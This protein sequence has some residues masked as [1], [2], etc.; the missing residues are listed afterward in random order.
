MKISYLY[1]S[2]LAFVLLGCVLPSRAD[3]PSTNAVTD[4]WIPWGDSTCVSNEDVLFS[5]WPDWMV[6]AFKIGGAW[7]TNIPA[8]VVEAGDTNEAALNIEVDR[9]HLTNNVLMQLDYVDHSNATLML[10]LYGFPGTNDPNE[11]VFTSNLF[12]NLL[13]GGGGVTSRTFTIPFGLYTNATGIRLRRDAGAM[14][15]FDT[16]LSSDRDGDGYSD[17]EELAWGSDLDSAL[18]VP[19]AA[20][21]GQVFYVGVQMGVIHVLAT[22]NAADWASAHYLTLGIPG[23][24]TLSGLPLRQT[25]YPR[26]F[27]DVNGNGIPDDWEPRG[28]YQAPNGATSLVLTGNTSGVNITL[29]DPDLD[30]DGMSDAAERAMGLDPYA[31]ND[32]TRLPFLD[33]FETNT[34][35]V[36]DVNGQNGWIASPSNTVLVQTNVVWEGEQAIRFHSGIVTSEVHRLF[37]QLPGQ[38]SW[39][40]FHAVAKVDDIPQD[41][42]NQ[43]AAFLFDPQGRLVVQDGRKPAGQKWVTL[44][45][46]PPVKQES[47]VRLSISMDFAAQR[48]LICLN[49]MKVAEDLGFG[50]PASELHEFAMEGGSGGLD[51]FSVSTNVPAGLSLDGDTL[52]DDW[53]MQYMGNTN[54]TESGDSDHD[55]V[56]NGEEYR[57]GTSP[58]NPD[59]DNDSMPDGW[60]IAH[61]LNPASA[62]DGALDS[63]LDG[64]SNTSE[65]LHGTDLAKSDSDN[66]GL[67]DGTEVN[68]WHSNPLASDSDLDGFKDADEVQRGTD[69]ADAESHPASHWRNRLKL[70][71]RDGVL[72]NSLADVPVLIRLTPER[73]DYSQCAAAGRDILFTDATGAPLAFELERWNPGGESLFWVR[74]PDA[75]GTNS[76]GYFWLHY[77]NPEATNSSNASATWSTNFLGVWHLSETNTVLSDSAPAAHPATN[78]G[79]V[80]VTGILGN[81]RNFRGSDSVIVPPSALATISNA[82]SISFWQ[83][84]ATNQ[85]LGVTCFEGTSV[86]GRELNAHVPWSDSNVYW[87]AFGNYDRINKLATTNL[88]KGGWNHWTFT[89][90]RASGIMRIYVNG[91]LWHSGTGKTRAYSPVTA[92]WFG[93]AASGSSGYVGMLDELRVE[94]LAQSPEWIRFQ[95]K[96]MTD[97]ILVYGEQQVSIAGTA[98]GAEPA[99]AGTF[100]LSRLAQDTNLALSV[101]LAVPGGAATEGADFSAIPRTVVIPSGAPQVSFTVP[102][103]DDLWLEGAETITVTI[104]QGNYFINPTNASASIAI[105]DDDTDTDNDGLCDGWE[106]IHFGNLEAAATDDADGDG[107]DNRHEFLNRTDPHSSDSDNDGLPDQWEITKGTAPLTPD[108][109]ADPDNDGL[110]NMQE[111]QLGTNPKS[112]DTD[113]DGMPDKWEVDHALNPLVNDAS[114]DP[115]SDGLSNLKEYQA[116]SDPHNPDTDG[117]GLSDGAEVN[118]YKTSP[119]KSDT[120]SDG[121]PDKW[122]V[123]NGTNPLVNDAAA[124]P[125]GDQLLNS[126]EYLAGTKPKVADTDGDGVNDKVEIMAYADPLVVDFNGTVTDLLVLNGRDATSWIG[127]WA[128]EGVAI[129]ARERSGSLDYLLA[130]PSNGTFAVA[131][132]VTQQNVLTALNTFDLSLFI[133]GTISGRQT[134]KAPYGTN[135]TATFFLPELAAGD[136]VIR[137]RWNND[138]PNTFLKVNSLK[139]QS[140]GGLDANTNGIPDWLDHRMASLS[141]TGPVPEST[142]VSPICMEGSAVYQERLSIAAS[143]AP[144]GQTQQIV[145]VQHGLRTTWFAN[146]FISPTNTTEIVT[147]DQSSGVMV[148]NNVIWEAVNLLDASFSNGLAIRGGSSLRLS[149]WPVEATN[150]LATFMVSTGTNV[151]TNLVAMVGSPVPY[152]FSQ[153]GNFTVLGACSN[154]TTFT[155]GSLAVQVISGSFNGEEAECVTG[156]ARTWDCPGIKTDA[157]VQADSQLSVSSTNLV[158]GGTRFTLMNPTDGPFYMVARLGADGPVLD[159]AKISSIR[160]DHGTYF[161][162]VET[163]ADG[164]RMVEVRLQLGYVPSDLTVVLHIFAGGVTF[165]DGTLNKTLTAADFNELGVCT[166]RMLQSASS[167]SSTCHTTKLYQGG[168]YI[169]GN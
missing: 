108:S 118:T 96:A 155:N 129:S 55:G 130:I 103:L 123:D 121:L 139:L 167:R 82:V 7:N 135:C 74:L 49:G 154:E 22:T 10:D 72:T 161:K 34:V 124:D 4:A 144:G 166:Y 52:P 44:T 140:F 128:I 33:R 83:Y 143:Y 17:S 87:D 136:H 152:C 64:L 54:E 127:T 86:M 51:Q 20:I 26:A 6:S 89:K 77:N 101:N 148:S 60:E 63:D 19:C 102:T 145:A 80:C 120:D 125:D 11:P 146:V 88:F 78:V 134:V 47:W 156:Q 21:T 71:F 59:S 168:L 158:G 40:D 39:V 150:G 109:G 131:V 2:V 46:V 62:A 113:S 9:I 5:P 38:I 132:N 169:G 25:W 68:T 30:G 115:D 31:S 81:A 56:N 85:P 43:A 165:L 149:A 36:G 35:H 157:V 100:T 151:V 3:N 99:Q 122:E 110:T 105:I 117:D 141:E 13:S 24:Y 29:T 98:N 119:L 126:G 65:Y 93:A 138:T 27:R 14:T 92:F 94:S 114:A 61:A 70:S 28:G 69:P 66:D 41:M 67:L 84:G 8:W 48:W 57:L 16:L 75:G 97:Q 162:V 106:M 91:E 164:S 133:D 18:S 163:F 107:V 112:A 116:S 73:V 159:S 76:T 90:D 1:C 15:I 142:L 111:Y 160:G 37:A 147:A 58:A 104:A 23:V 53:E 95:Y 50:I 45:N 42:T 32:F 137:L 153:A 12:N 79:A